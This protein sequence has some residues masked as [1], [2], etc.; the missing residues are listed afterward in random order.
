MQVEV[1]LFANFRD[2]AGDSKTHLE[3][4]T[5][6]ELLEKL[7]R[8]Y[9]AL[10]GMVLEE[11][12]PDPELKNGVSVLLNGRNIRFLDGVSTKFESGD[13]VAIFPPIGGG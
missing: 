13:S 4:S 6:G 10:E 11:G 1:K 3:A 2:K 12:E 7:V 8:K 9:D 5:A